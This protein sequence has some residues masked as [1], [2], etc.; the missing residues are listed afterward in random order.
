MHFSSVNI[1]NHLRIGAKMRT[2]LTIALLAAAAS[3]FSM[4]SLA[5]LD[6][7][8]GTVQGMHTYGDGRVLVS[9][10]NFSNATC[11]N[12]S[13]FVIYGSHPHFQRLLA[14]IL[15]AKAMGP[16]LAVVAKS[17]NCWYPEITQDSTT[18]I[19]ANP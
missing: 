17:D 6:S 1:T 18:Y 2:K 7:A 11:S 14:I 13:G 19:Y 15:T 4:S 16:T 5:A 12:N 3:L 10:F 8:Q 9:G